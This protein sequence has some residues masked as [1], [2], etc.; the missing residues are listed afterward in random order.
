MKS[1]GSIQRR[2]TVAALLTVGVSVGLSGVFVERT[3][4]ERMVA[5]AEESLETVLRIGSMRATGEARLAH[6]EGREVS[7]DLVGPGMSQ[8]SWLVEADLPRD[9]DDP[10]PIFEQLARTADFPAD[11]FREQ[12]LPLGGPN[13]SGESDESEVT[14]T[15]VE[16]SNGELYRVASYIMEPG[17]ERFNGKWGGGGWRSDGRG[18]DRGERG[19]GRMDGRPEGRFEGRRGDGPGGGS[20]SRRGGPQ[21]GEL[22]PQRG[23]GGG[24]G[25]G[26]RFDDTFR[27]SVAASIAEER[28]FLDIL[29]KTL[30]LA[31]ALALVFSALLIPWAVRR[32][33]R[34][35]RK[36][37]EE[38]GRMDADRLDHAL[39]IA[40][41]PAELAPIV[42]SLEGA[43]ERLSEAFVRE[44]R[45]TSDAAH[46]LRTPLAG[47]RA[48]MEVALRRERSLDQY[49]ETMT[50]CLGITESM[51]GMVDSLLLLAK[52]AAHEL[53]RSTVDL[54]S[55]LE[56]ALA[57]RA[58]DMST[59][60]LTAEVDLGD[61]P[62]VSSSQVLIERI[63][64]NIT[65][66]AVQYAK[67]GSEIACTIGESPDDV[68]WTVSNEAA[69]LPSDTAERAFD[70]LWRADAA[71]SDASLHAGLGLTLV[72]QCVEALGGSVSVEAADERFTIK[73]TLPR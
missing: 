45:F 28:A 5:G 43:R 7:E 34:P 10:Q 40:A 22:G 73:V 19:E 2:L 4:R 31:G 13:D 57:N 16:G 56:D 1:G 64:A 44:K 59:R 27:V 18:D 20:L 66:N 6:R 21:R 53:E 30:L 37:S 29:L 69:D 58:A 14:F 11:K 35:V 48:S 63:F 52:G 33:L 26:S 61:R 38:I 46:E 67:E 71:R 70:P 36:I 3:V 24:P 68:W 60:G 65:R 39:E 62:A 15:V 42:N 8:F 23:R 17:A 25:P 9:P 49:R 12:E 72:A 54:A 50:E 55:T 51:Q 47:L 41:P 32:G